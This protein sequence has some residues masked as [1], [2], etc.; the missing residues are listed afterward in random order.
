MFTE[1][2]Q[3]KYKLDG[4]K[5]EIGTFNGINENETLVNQEQHLNSE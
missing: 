5:E 2:S 3:I 4:W 1:P